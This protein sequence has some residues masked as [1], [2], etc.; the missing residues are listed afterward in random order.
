MEIRAGG[1]SLDLEI[2]AGGGSSGPGNP[3]GGG[4]GKKNHAIR[5]GGADFFWNNPF[6]VFILFY[7][8]I[9]AVVLISLVFLSTKYKPSSGFSETGP[10]GDKG[11]L[12][13]QY[14]IFC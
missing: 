12:Y 3:G 2:R 6:I 11:I 7:F 14:Y 10:L 13:V 1:G 8:T 4:G 9:P 5:Q